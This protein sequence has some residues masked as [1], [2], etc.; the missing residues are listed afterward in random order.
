MSKAPE[1]ASEKEES[2]FWDT[3]D[4]TEF[5]DETEPVEMT[6]VDARPPKKQI[7]LRLDHTV[8][9]KLKTIS[10]GRGIGYQTMIRM[11]VMDR[12]REETHSL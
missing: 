2:E 5:L 7:S 3:H 4:S 6:F 11:W 9:E 12:L 10:A 1:F 8:I